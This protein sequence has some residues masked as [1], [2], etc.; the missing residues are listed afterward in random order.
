[1]V[2]VIKN[3]YFVFVRKGGAFL[4]L[5][6]FVILGLIIPFFSAQAIFILGGV[7]AAFGGAIGWIIASFLLVVANLILALSSVILMWS[8]DPWFIRVP[9]T[10]GG[11]VAIGWPIVRDL[12]NMG[13][14]L[15][16]VVIGLATALR[17]EEYQARKTLPPLIIIALLINFTPVILG[18]IVDA[19]NIVMEFFLEELTGAELIANQFTALGSMIASDL[20]GIQIFNPIQ[21]WALFFK[22][23]VMIIF[24]LV[25]SIIF[26]LFAFLF[27]MRRVVIWMLVIF[28]PLAFVAYILPAT[29]RLWTMWWNQFIQWSIIGVFAAFFLYLGEQMIILASQ[30]GFIA[31][32]PGGGPGGWLAGHTIDVLSQVLPYFV[33]LLFLLFGFFIA[34]T[35]SAFGSAGI[36]HFARTRTQKAAAW[37]RTKGLERGK[38]YAK[39]RWQKSPKAE[40]ISKR[41]AEAQAPEEVRVFGKKVPVVSQVAKWGAA[42]SVVGARA[43]GRAGIAVREMGPTDVAREMEEAKKKGVETKESHLLSP[44]KTKTQRVSTYLAAAEQGQLKPLEK[45]IEA[46][47]GAEKKEALIEKLGREA[48]EIHP[49]VF[50]MFEKARLDIANKLAPSFS[51]ERREA[52]GWGDLTEK[53]KQRYGTILNK[54]MA[55][56][57]PEE[58]AKIAP[59]ALKAT[60]ITDA[61]HLFWGGPQISAAA[62]TFGLEFI[63]TFNEEMRRRGKKWYD[64]NNP[65][66][67]RYLTRRAGAGE[68]GFISEEEIGPGTEK[69]AGQPPPP[70]PEAP[71]SP[72]PEEGFI[73]G[74]GP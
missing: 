57:K 63:E 3:F 49:D 36:I 33:A 14:V 29:R 39:E 16:L 72:P 60:E 6:F 23:L 27:I 48:M 44:E 28:S 7:A 4:A 22:I 73:G 11:I 68:L 62:R 15:A 52:A 13:I 41:L 21:H 43:I 67:L 61:M 35:T 20:G 51:K 59:S 64:D 26:L 30:G 24:N 37:A 5:S 56:M 58:I 55:E 45:T 53:E 47:L 50:K 66:V 70:P 69:V 8:I 31:E 42:A 12:A 1:M 2:Q 38:T 34:L 19:T 9:Y 18:F 54:K 17:L 65:K 32:P 74:K 46:R 71:P 25:A 10:S 40:K